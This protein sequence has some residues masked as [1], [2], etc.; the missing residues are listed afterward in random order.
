MKEGAKINIV[1]MQ[2]VIIRILKSQIR[3]K[4]PKILSISFYARPLPPTC[5]FLHNLNEL[6]V[7]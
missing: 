5:H 3:A 6:E 2:K 1:T 4:F 7:F